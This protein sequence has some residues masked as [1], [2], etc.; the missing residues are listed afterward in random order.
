MGA[1][2][3]FE[4]VGFRHGTEAETLSNVTF[5]LLRGEIA[6]VS[7]A[8]GSGK[9]AL[10]GLAALALVPSRGRLRLF[11]Q[12]LGGASPRLRRTLRRR[13][14]FVGDG[15]P[16]LGGL[17]ARDNVA[18]PLEVLGVGT[19]DAEQRVA[20]LLDW[21]GL[22]DRAD[23]TPEALSRAERERVA[24]ARAVVGRPEL[25]V[26]DDPL[27]FPD[28]EE[29][30]RVCAL[31]ERLAELGSAVLVTARAPGWTAALPA[32]RLRIAGGRLA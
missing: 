2:L 30:G 15:L 28:A 10:A 8:G 19:R 6:V 29:A 23:A 16:L 9:S 17:S 32:K 11:D 3:G 25:V 22:S 21:M 1:I 27:S 20:E 5:A 7:G 12:D 26:A 31:L 14:G 24:I 4:T 13:I 18:L